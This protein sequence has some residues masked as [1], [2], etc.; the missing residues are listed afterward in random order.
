E[1]RGFFGLVCYIAAFLPSIADHTGILTELTMKDSQQY[2]PSW[3]PKYQMAFDTVKQILT[4]S[5][6]LT[7]INF[8]K[9]A[10]HKIFVTTDASDKCSGT[11]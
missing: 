8:S 5:D 11:V 10:D 7:T 2:F 6:C 3:M 1:V 9:M 4:R